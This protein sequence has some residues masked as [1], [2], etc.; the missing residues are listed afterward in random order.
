V[1]F[2]PP[3]SRP[4]HLSAQ[5]IIDVKTVRARKIDQIKPNLRPVAERVGFA[6]VES[7]LTDAE[8]RHE[9]LR[10]VQCT[11]FC[12]KC[13]EVCPNRSNYTFVMRPVRWS[14]P[15]LGSDGGRLVVT[16]SEEFL[17][18]QERQILHVDDFCN[19]CDNC[20]TFCVHHGKPYTDKPRLF[21]DSSL[22]AA[23]DSN[24]FHIDGDTIR[25]RE[26]G[27]E[28]RLSFGDDTLTFEDA[29]VKV[30]LSRDWQVRAMIA[31]TP[32]DGIRSL[33]PAAEMAVLYEG[34]SS[35]LPFLLI[36]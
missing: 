23:E 13:V 12:D 7:T 34:V 30:T 4:A 21:L 14:L 20:Q 1:H 27:C 16:G 2:A 25:R 22:F 32:F 3:F 17:V 9:G 31:K 24:A 6:L 35:A 29:T 11:A 8:A 36:R 5:D 18:V 33:R 10:C 28:S 26:R 15:V 19:E